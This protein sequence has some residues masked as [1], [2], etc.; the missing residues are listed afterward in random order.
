MATFAA[1]PV[2]TTKPYVSGAAYIDKMGDSCSAC[3]FSPNST[4]PIT[5][6]YW[7]FLARHEPALR[8][9]PR[10]KHVLGSLRRRS[11][12]DRGRDEAAFVHVRDVLV[13]GGKV[14]PDSVAAAVSAA[15]PRV[16]G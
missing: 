12:L 10:M 3:R 4:C 7:A 6:L 13:R 9:N 2:M 11:D 1:G 14:T 5:R 15:Q 8:S 16:A